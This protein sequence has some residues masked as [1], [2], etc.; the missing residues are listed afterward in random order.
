MMC[1]ENKNTSCISCVSFYVTLLYQ[2]SKKCQYQIK[3]CIFH[4]NMVGYLE[5]QLSKWQHIAVAQ[6]LFE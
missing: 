6:A 5:K 2:I 3:H 1:C 4:A